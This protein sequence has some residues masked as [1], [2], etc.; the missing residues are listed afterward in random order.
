MEYTIEKYNSTS[1]T[2]YI[3]G[4]GFDLAHGIKSS[5]DDY[6]LFYSTYNVNSCV[7][8]YRIRPKE[9]EYTENIEK[10]LD[11]KLFFRDLSGDWSN[12]EEAIGKYDVEDIKE[13]IESEDDKEEDFTKQDELKSSRLQFFFNNTINAL[14]ILFKKWVDNI[15]IR[16]KA[17]PEQYKFNKDG[18]FLSFNYTEVLE[19]LYGI[20][21][22]NICY[23][24][25][26]RGVDKEYIFGHNNELP[27]ITIPEEQNY[28][29]YVDIKKEVID[30]MNEFVKPY[31]ECL[32]TLNHYI[33]KAK[34]EKV[35]VHGHSLGSVDMVYLEK[36]VEIIGSDIP[37][38]I[39]YYHEDEID[40]IYKLKNNLGLATVYVRW[41]SRTC[42]NPDYLRRKSLEEVY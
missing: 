16:V 20:P 40:K 42:F 15:D 21:M 41:V 32:K 29:G 2:L 13:Y 39:D 35:I 36:I 11:P 31:D 17:K 28:I 25:G 3:I 34:I 6:K 12:I 4:N 37:W 9:R 10:G 8:S 14:R 22:N 1:K 7:S 23:I 5:Y 24:H 26:R 30:K 33:Q 27:A 38:Q 18:L 19:T